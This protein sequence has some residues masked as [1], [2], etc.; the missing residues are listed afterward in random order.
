LYLTSLE[1]AVQGHFDNA[2]A[3]FK[4]AFEIRVNVKHWHKAAETLVRWGETL[5]A[6]GNQVEALS[7]Y[8]QVFRIDIKHN[9]EEIGFQEWI[10]SDI[11]ALGRMLKVLGASQFDAVWQEVMGE[12]CP[13][14]VRSAIQ[15]ASEENE[16]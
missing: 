13:E 9:H 8:I 11:K 6:Q 2:I 14:E 15:A 1:N 10:D 5:E 16:E 3:Y 12:E 7:K 4:K